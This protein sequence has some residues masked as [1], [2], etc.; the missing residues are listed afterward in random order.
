MA[1]LDHCP[2]LRCLSLPVRF[3]EFGSIV[4]FV[5]VIMSMEERNH[6]RMSHNPS[7]D[8]KVAVKVEGKQDMKEKL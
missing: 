8:E 5:E 2:H 3:V 7:T 1:S 4:N 6:D